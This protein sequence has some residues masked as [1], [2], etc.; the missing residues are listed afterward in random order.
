LPDWAAALGGPFDLVVA[1]PPY[2][3]TAA[4][5]ALA[6]EVA[7]AEPSL[8]LDGGADGLSAY[9]HILPALPGLL[10]PWGGFAIEAGRG[11]AEAVAALATKAGLRVDG[12]FKDLSGVDRVVH[13]RRIAG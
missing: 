6:P 12:L 9:R 4:I 5:P 7:L 13:G 10:K 8:A 1:N 3:E 2:I 11:Q